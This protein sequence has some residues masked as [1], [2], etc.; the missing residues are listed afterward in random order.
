MGFR[1]VSCFDA[2]SDQRS[3]S[4]VV[5]SEIAISGG[6][7]VGPTGPTGPAGGGFSGPTG[8]FDIIKTGEIQSL[9]STLNIGCNTSTETINIGC[10]TGSPGVQTVNIGGPTGGITTINIG[11]VG[12]T[13]VV[14]GTMFIANTENIDVSN[15]NITLNAS[16]GIDSA[17]GA[18]IDISDNGITGACYIR[19]SPD[20]TKFLFKTPNSD[21]LE[22]YPSPTG[23]TGPTG[24]TGAT[25]VVGSTGLTG[26]TGDTGPT[27]P[28]GATGD[29]GPT[30][31][32]GATGDTGPFT[33]NP[34]CVNI[35]T[36]TITGSTGTFTNLLVENLFSDSITGNI[37]SFNKITTN[38]IESFLST[39]NIGCNTG[40]QTI[41]IGCGTGSSGVQ[42][43]NIG[44]GPN[45]GET[46]INIGGPED[47]VI[48]QGTLVNVNTENLDV[49][50]KTITLNV[51]GL[52]GSAGD[53]GI[54]FNEGG[55]TGSGY[56]KV[57]SDRNNI[58]VKAP[59]GNPFALAPIQRG[60]IQHLAGMFDASDITGTYSFST[61]FLSS[62]TVVV[63]LDR[64]TGVNNFSGL[65]STHSVSTNNFSYK[66]SNISPNNQNEIS[67]GGG[68]IIDSLGVG[69]YTSLQVVEG[70]PAISYRDSAN[71]DLKFIRALDSTG[72]SWGEGQTIDSTGTVGLYTSLQVVEG[73]PAISYR[74][75]TSTK[76]DLKFIRALDSTG[77]RWAQPQTIDSTGSVGEHT[78]LQVVNGNPSIAYYDNS[79]A[80]LKFI[81]A[82]DST[83]WGWGSGQ[84]IDT[85]GTV[86]EYTSLQVVNGNPAI[87]YYDR[88]NG[89]L[90]FIRALDSIGFLWGVPRTIDNGGIGNVGEFTSLQV[91][92][93]NPAI[94]Y[95]DGTNGD[96][97]FIR[98]LDSTGWLW[99]VPQLLDSTGSVG[100][101]TSLQIV[102]GFP[103]ISYQDV[104]STKLD[105]KFIRALDSTGGRWGVPQTVD[106]NG[107]VG[108]FTSLQVIAGNPAISYRDT[109]NGSLKFIRSKPMSIDFNYIAI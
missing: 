40:T 16:G 6:T 87:S 75:S 22:L 65:V 7:I 14:Q 4:G 66:I 100:D 31:P 34:T 102:G 105:L 86:G 18:G 53:A 93:G 26:P 82:L 107:T 42:T 67:W 69:L 8:T 79:N 68:Q 50:D 78:S 91:V 81:R 106:S 99:G 89:D 32:T 3:L 71:T 84:T 21:I 90:K 19:V 49:K 95:H 62:P 58:V 1:L 51:G 48:V 72:G 76:L 61:P 94:S 101:F 83:G 27:G 29:T 109:T 44:K 104:T 73:N 37:G 52:T 41:N 85:T 28:T 2:R 56:I 45:G 64:G 30:G 54:N 25:G 39:L 24:P 9:F 63:S 74:D 13:V 43:V 35:I 36:Q 57:S 60:K 46:T 47:T 38:E 59:L 70:N 108:E 88:T 10:S 77:G 97:K 92:G 103:A 20:R 96:L 12:D 15:K 5:L 98:A 17:F 55:N 33:K 23:D 80:D 11:G